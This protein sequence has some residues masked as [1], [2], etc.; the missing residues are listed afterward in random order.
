[1]C[2][3]GKSLYIQA[4][5]E[6]LQQLADKNGG[7]PPFYAHL[8]FRESSSADSLVQ[9]LCLLDEPRRAYAIHVDIGTKHIV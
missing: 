4:E 1:M 3:G 8:A 9:S 6:E 5:V 2:G 7:S